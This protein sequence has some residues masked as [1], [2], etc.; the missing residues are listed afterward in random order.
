MCLWGFYL[1]P[2]LLSIL[3]YQDHL[4]GVLCHIFLEVEEYQVSWLGRLSDT[5]SLVPQ[6]SSSTLLDKY[7]PSQIQGASRKLESQLLVDLFLKDRERSMCDRGVRHGRWLFW[8]V[9]GLLTHNKAKDGI[10]FFRRKS[11]LAIGDSFI[12]LSSLC[13]SHDFLPEH[14]TRTLE[15]SERLRSQRF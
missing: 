2:Q 11:W 6:A 15:V 13:A 12:G 4:I 9:Q 14:F 10:T 1:D 5:S 8:N 7:S 3:I